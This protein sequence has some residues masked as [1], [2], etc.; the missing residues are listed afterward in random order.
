MTFSSIK[1]AVYSSFNQHM[2]NV[3]CRFHFFNSSKPGEC[4][5]LTGAEKN[6]KKKNSI[7]NNNL[8]AGIIMH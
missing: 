4:L 1:D 3:K 6:R 7:Q 8:R 5:V 2:E